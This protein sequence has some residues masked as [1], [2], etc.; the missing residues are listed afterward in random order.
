M[1]QEMA[2]KMEN[3]ITGTGDKC[4]NADKD[5]VKTVETQQM[6]DITDEPGFVPDNNIDEELKEQYDQ[7]NDDPNFNNKQ[8]EYYNQRL[9][10]EILKLNYYHK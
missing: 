8:R 10:F 3:Q 4:S 5:S 2:S 7:Y 1:E 6:L 9:G